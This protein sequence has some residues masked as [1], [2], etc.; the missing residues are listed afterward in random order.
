MLTE[1]SD[2]L[3]NQA[4]GQTYIFLVRVEKP[5]GDVTGLRGGSKLTQRLSITCQQEPESNK[6]QMQQSEFNFTLRCQEI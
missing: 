4:M 3:K 6:I 5:E 1:E 2:G